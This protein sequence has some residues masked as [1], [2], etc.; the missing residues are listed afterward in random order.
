VIR[1]VDLPVLTEY[2]EQLVREHHVAILRS[3]A[4]LD[5]QH[6]ALTVNVADAYVR[7]LRYATR[8]PPE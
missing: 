8:R 6:H 5:A 2:D 1:L 4:L 3:L 7:N